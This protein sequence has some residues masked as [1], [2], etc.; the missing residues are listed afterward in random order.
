MNV[1]D[2]KS[3]LIPGYH[4]VSKKQQEEFEKSEA[5]LEFQRI[6]NFFPEQ[7]KIFYWPFLNSK[8]PDEPEPNEEYFALASIQLINAIKETNSYQNLMRHL[9]H[10]ILTQYYADFS[11]FGNYNQ[12]I[13]INLPHTPLLC[14]K[15]LLIDRKYS[16]ASQYIDHYEAQRNEYIDLYPGYPYEQYDSYDA[17]KHQYWIAVLD[18]EKQKISAC[19]EEWTIESKKHPLA[20]EYFKNLQQKKETKKNIVQE[21]LLNRLNGKKAEKYLDL[22]EE[23]EVLSGKIAHILNLNTHQFFNGLD[24]KTLNQNMAKELAEQILNE[25][26]DILFEERLKIAL[27][28]YHQKLIQNVQL[29]LLPFEEEYFFK[30][31]HQLISEGLSHLYK[32]SAEATNLED[33][34]KL[35]N[36]LCEAYT[37]LHA[38][39]GCSQ[40]GDLLS[41]IFDTSTYFQWRETIIESKTIMGSLLKPFKPI[42]LEY[43]SVAQSE[44]NP[45]LN[46]FRIILPI[47]VTAGFVFLIFFLIAAIHIPEAAA[48]ILLIPT[49][50]LGL[51]LASQLIVFRLFLFNQFQEYFYGRY[52]TPEFQINQRMVLGLGEEEAKNI[53]ETYV[54]EIK[55]C[56]DKLESYEK[57]TNLNTE[58]LADKK[59]YLKKQYELQIEWYD[60][61]SNKNIGFDQIANLA[62]KRL[63]K[64]H[65]ELCLRIEEHVPKIEEDIS[66]QALIVKNS[67]YGHLLKLRS[68]DEEKFQIKTNP[69]FF[70]EQYLALKEKKSKTEALISSLED[71]S[72]PKLK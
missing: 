49:V 33:A 47:A 20:Q 63:S 5:G 54:H 7:N 24:L 43:Y 65:D 53:Q 48:I 38:I 8:S 62:S 59:N 32:A 66:Q 44:N 9:Y 12:E 69:S 37:F 19:I 50:Y 11:L 58:E 26:D 28:I 64:I 34:E 31:A 22:N 46:A 23:I 42:Y 51:F 14:K 56:A 67:V 25:K 30:A 60:I 70:S 17:N 52:Q 57:K 71:L 1:H 68:G 36:S 16:E 3:T 21:R 41:K 39:N 27:D 45:L 55:I 61:H 2:L 15:L 29:V 40:S 10:A 35:Y 13:I 18:K 72:S 6:L 4:F